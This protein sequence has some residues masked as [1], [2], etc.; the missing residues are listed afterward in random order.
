M[1][2]NLSNYLTVKGTDEVIDALKIKSDAV[3]EGSENILGFCKSFND[4][5]ETSGGGI[6]YSWLYDNVGTKWIYLE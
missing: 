3:K 6:S 5:V 2:N 4:D 1:A